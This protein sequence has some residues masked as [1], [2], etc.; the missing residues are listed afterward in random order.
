[1][2]SQLLTQSSLFLGPSGLLAEMVSPRTSLLECTLPHFFQSQLAP[3]TK[4][5]YI[6]G[7]REAGF[8]K[9]TRIPTG[10]PEA[11]LLWTPITTRCYLVLSR[12]CL[13]V[14]SSSKGLPDQEMCWTSIQHSFRPL[15][16]NIHTPS[17]PSPESLLYTCF[18]PFKTQDQTLLSM[19]SHVTPKPSQS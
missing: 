14:Q 17:P 8:K 18:S 9:D 12:Y 16:S 7:D 11:L 4:H 5:R 3:P 10:S 1:M 2:T 13:V 19:G 15:F 6:V